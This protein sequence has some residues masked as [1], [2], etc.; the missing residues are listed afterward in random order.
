MDAKKNC[1]LYLVRTS[2]DDLAML[3]KSLGLAEAN[4]LSS[5][6]G[7]TDIILFH[8][9]S[10]DQEYR[11]RVRPVAN[12]IILFQEIEFKLP[13]YPEETKRKIPALYPHPTHAHSGFS[14]GY[15]HMCDFFAGSLYEQPVLQDYE[16]YLRLD[17]D[18]FILSKIP[19]DIFG[20]MKAHACEY[21]Y[22]EPALQQD[23]PKVIERLWDETRQW[24]QTHAVKTYKPLEA[25]P[26]G[27]MFYTNFELGKV[28]SFSEGSNYYQFYRFI[29]STGNIFIKRWGDAP[30]K[31]LGVNLFIKPE[32]VCPVRG[33]IYQHGATYD[34]SLWRN[35]RFVRFL[36]KIRDSLS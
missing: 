18:S 27:R 33:F 35:M 30:I 36:R 3:N 26:E 29:R 5:V 28:S 12:G 22:I 1:I 25:I 8:E 2:T 34:L 24:L 19:Y 13:E 17:T 15:R 10:F 9:K 31:Y 23:H 6:K 20:W 4:V 14:M 11:K 21:G 16:Y 32:T 7:K